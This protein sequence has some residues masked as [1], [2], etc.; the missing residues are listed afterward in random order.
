MHSFCY[1]QGQRWYDYVAVWCYNGY[2]RNKKRYN[3]QKKITEAI[4]LVPF[5]VNR[6][7]FEFSNTGTTRAVLLTVGEVQNVTRSKI[8]VVLV[9]KLTFSRSIDP[10]VLSVTKP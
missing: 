1:A 9:L 6:I 7:E 2:L 3:L 4:F 8:H 5:L 10:S